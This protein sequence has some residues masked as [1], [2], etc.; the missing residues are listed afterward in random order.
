MRKLLSGR[1]AR[2][3]GLFM[4]FMA[5]SLPGP[6][7]LADNP[8]L[9]GNAIW[10][11]PEFDAGKALSYESVDIRVRIWR[12][13]AETSLSFTIRNKSDEE[14]EANL[15]F[16]LPEGAVVNGYALDIEGAMV[17]GI[18]VEKQKA[19][20]V[21]EDTV[22]DRVD[23]G[24]AGVERNNL[25]RTRI[26][27]VPDGESRTVQ[28]SYVSRLAPKGAYRLPLMPGGKVGTV[29]LTVEVMDATA[30]PR[31]LLPA[32]LDGRWA[33]DTSTG[34]FEGRNITLD[35]AISVRAGQGRMKGPLSV[36]T[37]TDGRH[38]FEI[39]DT[40][41]GHKSG[42]RRIG[43]L[44]VYWDRSL[45]RAGRNHRDAIA[46]IEQVAALSRA[47]R[48]E[49]VAF[50]T[51]ADA[52]ETF[53]GLNR[54]GRLADAIRALD[55]DGASDFGAGLAAED[56]EADL[57]IL[58]SD[59]E[60]SL[61]MVPMVPPRCDLHVIADGANANL[62][63]LHY[64]ARQAHGVLH[65]LKSITTE[66][67]ART[68]LGRDRRLLDANAEGA[69]LYSV[70]APD[71]QF[72]LVGMT[73]EPVAKVTVRFGA[74]GRDTATR[75][76]TIGTVDAP[77][78][79]GLRSMWAAARVADLGQRDHMDR[80]A[81]IDASQTYGIETSETSFLVLEDIEDYIVAGLT[82]PA[83]LP[84]FDADDY[85]YDLAAYQAEQAE[86]AAD[87]ARSVRE[88]WQD[89][90]AWW[91]QEHEVSPDFVAAERRRWSSPQMRPLSPSMPGYAPAG[92]EG[93]FEGDV[94]E[95][96][97]TGSLIKK[98]GQGFT[99][100]PWQSDRPYIQAL[101]DLTGRDF[102]S[103]YRRERAA[104]GSLPAF[105]FDVA[106]ML[107][108][109]GDA[110]GASDLAVN[111]LELP[112]AGQST[113]I[114][115][116]GKLLGY[117]DTDRAVAIYEDILAGN[118][119]VPQPARLMAL[120]LVQKAE[121]LPDAAARKPLY[122][123]ALDLLHDVVMTPWQRDYDGIDM[124][125][126]M[127]ANRIVVDLKALGDDYTPFEAE[128]MTLLD[129]DLRVVINW[130]TDATDMDLWVMEPTLERAYYGRPNTVIG[131]HL[132]NDMTDGYGPEEYLLR[133]A[134]D[135]TYK[136]YVHYYAPDQLRVD[137]PV[138]V[139]VDFYRNFGRADEVHQ[140]TDVELTEV[141]GTEIMVGEITI[142]DPVPEDG[143]AP[144]AGAEPQ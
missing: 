71:G 99:V 23:P 31:L 20:K 115:L 70:P 57:C 45:S 98:R 66:R 72:R 83:N 24:F 49:L 27:P 128:L 63:Y 7:A 93:V 138:T 80:A 125:S 122:H 140:S 133:R 59:G 50:S 6:A 62:A 35:Q 67:L 5:L 142:G 32:G 46:A 41:P 42:T 144:E 77:E 139:R 89:L 13:F 21:F 114:T 1:V 68:I 118:G 105:Y 51:R 75:S 38:Y 56:S 29:R 33:H 25:F 9:T 11:D 117:G 81:I 86:A 43:S 30:T 101:K 39:R 18:P 107:F 12:G 85:Q 78:F 17:P 47:K 10:A 111:V 3:V 88:G 119:F 65:S 112:T 109:R 82:P 26:Y 74:A 116:A 106:D 87:K 54:A 37:G 136:V 143:A 94:E 61:R 60:A 52:T 34:Q 55:Y 135:G 129:L 15:A 14:I 44:R 127:D 110:M 16:S 40:V 58:V 84:G 124:I 121:G 126:L 95:V 22:R 73:A 97:V 36:A 108:A 104:H 130:N 19:E 141:Q 134:A 64:L 69:T 131:G 48:L 120:A 102:Q 96:V 76:Y 4:A 132:S 28:F 103:A 100:R 92:M 137:G 113:L 79:E 91:Q 123:R 90:K 8:V 2:I 53:K